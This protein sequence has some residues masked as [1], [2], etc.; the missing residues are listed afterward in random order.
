VDDVDGSDATE[1]SP[2][3]LAPD[4]SPSAATQMAEIQRSFLRLTFWQTLLS[5]AGVFTGAVALYAALNESRAVR[6]QTA[7]AV[8]PYVQLMIN[9]TDDGETA[10]FALTFEN[11]GVGPALMR[12]MRLNFGDEAIVSWEAATNRL[13]DEPLRVGTDYGQSNISRRV[14]AP[15]EMVVAFQTHDRR[16]VKRMQEAVYG[17]GVDLSYCYCSIFDSCWESRSWQSTDAAG[18]DPVDRCMDHGEAA[19]RD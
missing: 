11:V 17:G 4:A 1:A 3:S 14:I 2:G 8:W 19:F 16:V 5:L 15:G 13:F 18:I 6:E 10:H 12:S 7:A 9:D